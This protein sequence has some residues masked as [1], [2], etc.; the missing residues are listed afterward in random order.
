M[1][2]K[3]SKWKR[4]FFLTKEGQDFIEDPKYLEEEKLIIGFLE[5][6]R[7]NISQIRDF[8][9]SKNIKT[10]W[11]ATKKFLNNLVNEKLIEEMK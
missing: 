9:L 7:K 1:K 6:G 11:S 10:D 5:D 2:P 4:E 8:L 3:K